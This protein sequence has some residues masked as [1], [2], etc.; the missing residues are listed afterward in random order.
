MLVFALAAAALAADFDHTHAAFA[1]FLQGAVSERGVDYGALK[2]REGQL[3]GYLAQ[4]AAA[5]PSSFSSSQKLAFAVNAY[6][7]FTIKTI[8]GAGPPASIMD[9]D[10]GKVWDTRRFTLA[11]GAV[12]LNAIENEQARKLTDGRVHAVLNCA[13]R[14]CPPLYTKPV[15][16]DTLGADLD[17]AARRWA[18]TNAFKVEGNTLYLSKIFDWYGDD[19]VRENK[20]DVPGID[21]KGEN[22]VWFLV[23]FVDEATKAKLAAGNL[24]VA[25]QDYDWALNRQ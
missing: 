25:W 11:G 13:S 4:L 17:G 7:A 20:G 5:D 1:T 8:L 12:T 19:F 2:G 23:R 22:A 14:G 21:G 18:R 6:N 3:D 16:A 15:T 24:T 9:L 10:G